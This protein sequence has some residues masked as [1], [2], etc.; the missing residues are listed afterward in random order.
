[1]ATPILNVELVGYFMP[2]F[3]LIL[4]FALV[5]ALLQHSKVFGDNKVLHGIIAIIIAIIVMLF[6]S[7][8]EFIQILAPW[9]A[10]FFIILIFIIML[11][12]V[13]GATDDQIRTVISHHSGIQWTIA[14]IAIVIV[15]GALASVFG[16]KSFDVGKNGEQITENGDIITVNADG[17]VTTLSGPTTTSSFGT[18]LSNTLYHPKVVGL[19]FILIIAAIAVAILSQ[20]P[21]RGWPE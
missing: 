20:R 14:I 18:N 9:F 5:Y 12:K 21:S 4:V 15:V 3:I 2:I 7:L 19:A 1:M 11:Y 6:S 13:F 16:Q 17:S 8:S 10:I